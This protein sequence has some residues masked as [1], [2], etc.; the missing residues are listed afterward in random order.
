MRIIRFTLKY[1]LP[2]AA[3]LTAVFAFIYLSVQQDLRMGLNDPQIQ[4]AEDAA[5]A[6]AA[7]QP[8]D[9]LIPANAAKVDMTQSLAPFL[10]VYDSSGSPVASGAS[11][12]NQVPIP[13]A[14]VFDYVRQ[15]K[16]DR[17]SWQPAPD[18]RSAAVIV[19]VN[20]GQ[21]GFVLAGR[22]MREVEDRESQLTNMV[23]TGW[24]AALVVT[25]VIVALLEIL[26][27]TRTQ[28]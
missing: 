22:G 1:W 26:P 14:G 3:A 8:V 10:I 21:G 13:P 2:L 28:V 4:M 20:G 7:N 15:H 24:L 17:V 19:A 5:S 23:M 12:N 16:E 27:Y 18:V 11:L 25:L 9:S 6:L